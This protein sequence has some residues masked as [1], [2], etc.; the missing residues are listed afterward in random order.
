MWIIALLPLGGFLSGWLYHRYG[1]SVEGGNNLL[2][3]EIHNSKKIIPLRMA[4]MVLFGTTLTHLFGG[5][6]GREGTALQMAASLADQLTKIFNFPPRDRQILLMAG[7]SGGFASVFGTPLAGTIF[8]LEV[9]V[10]GTIKHKA[11]F[12]C[13]VAA[14][15]G[16]R[17]TLNLGL[18]HTACRHAP[19]IPTITPIALISAIVA[20]ITFGIVAMLFAKL[21]HKIS[22]QFKSQISY[23]KKR[24]R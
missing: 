13:L 1:K 24:E 12:P 14:V 7:L 16:E 10:I 19:L 9:L 15:I 2:L 5:S 22:H 17:V 18:H 4:P 23:S 21:T 8:G 20:G 11:L 6:A 3:E